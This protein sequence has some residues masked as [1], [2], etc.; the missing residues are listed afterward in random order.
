MNLIIINYFVTFAKTI[1]YFESNGYIYTIP[2]PKVILNIQKFRNFLHTFKICLKI[3]LLLVWMRTFI[4][5][6]IYLIYVQS[7]CYTN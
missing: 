4:L 3:C 1:N 2:N 5:K 6:Y 7:N